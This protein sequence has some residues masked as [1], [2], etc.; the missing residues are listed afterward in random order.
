MSR[1]R[2]HPRILA[3]LTAAALGLANQSALA[4]R[5]DRGM[6]MNGM[7]Q[8]AKPASA[9]SRSATVAASAL[10]IAGVEHLTVYVLP[11]GGGLGFVGPDKAH[12]DTVVP[13]SFVLRRGVPVTVTVINFDD[14]RHS[15]T[16]PGLGIDIVIKPGLLRKGGHI[17]PV[18][19]TYIFT[20]TRVGEFR[21]F[22]L[23][24]CDMP[25]HW[26]MSASYDGPDRDGFMAGI[27]RVL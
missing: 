17:T 7:S 11:G 14:M 1:I 24:P 2:A 21:W 22:C 16:A 13:S 25:S 18:T 6:S 15:I 8:G 19:T 3:T 10:R 4:A 9:A 23:F 27:F 12:H 20:P 5:S 26:A